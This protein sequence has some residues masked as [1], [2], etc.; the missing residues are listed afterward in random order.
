MY[1]NSSKV[2]SS[3]HSDHRM[4]VT[5]ASAN[6]SYE[7]ITNLNKEVKPCF[8]QN[9]TTPFQNNLKVCW[10]FFQIKI[11]YEN[12]NFFLL[13]LTVA[14][15]L[16][17]FC[18]KITFNTPGCKEMQDT[19][20]G[21]QILRYYLF[22]FSFGPDL[23]T[24]LDRKVIVLPTKTSCPRSILTDKTYDIKFVNNLHI[25]FII[26]KII[27]IIYLLCLPFRLTFNGRDIS[28]M[29]STEITTF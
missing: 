28:L 4:I 17:Q 21:G 9:I 2:E 6:T 3:N 18:F 16:N 1:D 26:S 10:L 24:K 12:S 15:T 11:I 22:H 7:W 14:T 5:S 23:N 27:I 25:I 8:A 29:P 13:L 20:M 19:L